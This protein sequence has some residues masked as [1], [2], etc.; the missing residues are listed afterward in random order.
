MVQRSRS[1]TDRL[2]LRAWI[3]PDHEHPLRVQIRHRSD[4]EAVEEEQAFA[5]AASAATFVKVWL[6]GLVYRWEQGERSRSGRHPGDRDGADGADE[7][8][9][10]RTG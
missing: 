5:D 7:P 4:P 3:E 2:L 1:L 6:T 9:N 10:R 8:G